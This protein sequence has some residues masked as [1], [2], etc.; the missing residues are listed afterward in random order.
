MHRRVGKEKEV[1]IVLGLTVT[2][3]H[4]FA[5]AGHNVCQAVKCQEQNWMVKY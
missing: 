1:D 2:W 5:G 4:N 3:E